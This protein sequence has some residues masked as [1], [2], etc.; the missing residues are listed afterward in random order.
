MVKFNHTR[1]RKKVMTIDLPPAQKPPQLLELI[2][3]DRWW[4]EKGETMQ[5]TFVAAA[6]G[7]LG[8]ATSPLQAMEVAPLS[9]SAPAVTLVAGGCG[10]GFHRGPYGGCRPNGYV[11]APA[12]G[13]GVV[14]APGYHCG[15]G[16]HGGYHYGYHGGYHGGYHYHY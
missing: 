5:T 15:Y 2:L 16:W 10:L 4:F 3:F 12:V 7:L 13:Y 8:F 6:V 14:G 11:G 1:L 9:V